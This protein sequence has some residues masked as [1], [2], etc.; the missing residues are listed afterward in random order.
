MGQGSGYKTN[1]TF[2][3]SIPHIPKDF[4]YTNVGA[5]GGQNMVD[6]NSS[7]NT[8]DVQGGDNETRPLNVYMNFII[9]LTNDA[10]IPVGS[11]IPYAGSDQSNIVPPDPLWLACDGNKYSQRQFKDLFSV[12]GTRFSSSASPREFAVPIID[13]QFIRGVDLKAGRDPDANNRIPAPDGTKG[14]VVGTIQTYGTS[15]NGLSVNINNYPVDNTHDI[16]KTAGHDNLHNI[17]N[18]ATQSWSYGD[19]KESR[20]DNV[21]VTYYIKSQVSKTSNDFPVGGIIAVPGVGKIDNKFWAPCDGNTIDASNTTLAQILLN[22]WGA[23]IPNKSIQLPDLRNQ[24]LRTTDNNDSNTPDPFGDPDRANRSASGKGGVTSG[25]GSM[26]TFAT[27]TPQNPFSLPIWV[28]GDVVANA[29]TAAG[30][31][32]S[33][34]NSD[35]QSWTPAGGD[36]ETAPIYIAVNFFIKVDSTSGKDK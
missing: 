9:K 17:N 25:T 15:S 1:N 30:Y 4:H 31:T 10:A 18:A 28:A 22:A 16:F 2:S 23:G 14:P 33:E 13:G 26:Q 27:G 24:F 36:A 11:L 21:Y 20:P 12:I 34:W 29:A 8:F 5:T 35:W 3:V 32:T 6:W 7:S 19:A